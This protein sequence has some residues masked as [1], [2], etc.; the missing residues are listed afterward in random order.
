MGNFFKIFFASLLAF[1]AF[2]CIAFVCILIVGASASASSSDKPSLKN[3]SVLTL[4]VGET[5]K[6]QTISEQFSFA[7]VSDGQN[8]L[9]DMKD[10]ITYA[11]TD[12]KVKGIYIKLGMCSNGWATLYDMRKSLLDF[13]SSK[14]F[15]YAYGD[16]TDQK[17]LYLASIADSIFINPIGAVELKGLSATGTFYKK[18]LDK[19]EVTPVVFYCGKFKGASEPYRLE[20]FSEPNKQQI[21]DLLKDFYSEFVNA[22]A[23]KS[24]KDTA[25]I[26]ALANDLKIEKPADAVAEHLIDGI[27]NEH[28]FLALLKSK[29][30]KKDK[31]KIASMRMADYVDVAYVKAKSANKIAVLY[32]D[33]EIVDGEGE[34]GMV[35]A[36]PMI[37]E[38]RKLIEK[39]DVKAVVLR[40][41]SPGGSALASENMYQELMQLRK[42]K[43][44]IVSMGDVAA[45]GGY[46][47]SC[48]GDS[49]FA[50]P[51]T[52][53]GSIGVVGMMLNFE[54]FL[55]NKIGVTTDVVKTNTHADFPTVTRAMN[56]K[57]MAYMQ[58]N[59]DRIYGIFKQRVMDA[60]KIS[61]TFADSIA[62]GHV[63]SGTHALGIKLVDGIGG[64]DRALKSA[65]AI[66]N[67]K[68]YKVVYYPTVKDGV[69]ALVDKL[70]GKKNND[71]ILKEALGEDYATYK[72]LKTLKE[73][74]DKVNMMM[75]FTLEIK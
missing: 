31:E 62:Q 59:T 41:N 18:A 25:Y 75:P 50:Q 53:T 1:A 4:D 70:M 51:N 63:Y 5:I 3:N 14:K 72:K 40:I 26:S 35:A 10:A 33:G 54:N 38:I 71:V 61:Q 58:M 19:L 73:N 64:M 12:D 21:N 30:D 36:K 60:R 22:L 49:I 2:I 67:L 7:G 42:K 20:K 27:K 57:E 48:A 23:T 17:S 24:G 37:R 16:Y 15:I 68:D 13:K 28:E 44:I 8:G 47:L 69:E 52:I 6:E 43:P 39:D 55:K 66:A 29:T 74:M 11:K 65:A 45:S 56:E 32:A 34:Q 9:Q 46:Y